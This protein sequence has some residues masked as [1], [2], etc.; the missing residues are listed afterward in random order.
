[1]KSSN[2]KEWKF[3]Y[4]YGGDIIEVAQ[5]MGL[6]EAQI[7]ELDMDRIARTFGGSLNEAVSDEWLG[8]L[9]QAISAHMPRQKI[10]R[11]EVKE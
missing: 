1:M 11:Q 10:S 4:L 9:R 7:G 6:S 5:Q 8:W 3:C 2:K